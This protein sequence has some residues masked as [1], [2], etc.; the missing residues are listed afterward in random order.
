MKLKSID[1]AALFAR[2]LVALL[3]RG[4]TPAQA[5]VKLREALGPVYQP[6]IDQ[7]QPHATPAA[8]AAQLLQQST[9][10]RLR[11]LGKQLQQTGGNESEIF[12][13]WQQR[14]QHLDNIAMALQN[15]VTLRCAY[16]GLL[17]GI[18]ALIH[19]MFLIYVQPNFYQFYASL[20]ADAPI[21]MTSM[22]VARTMTLAGLLALIVLFMWSLHGK[23][24]VLR[25]RAG[26]LAMARFLPSWAQGFLTLGSLMHRPDQQ[27]P[28]SAMQSRLQQH[29]LLTG[30]ELSA[31]QLAFRNGYGDQEIDLLLS[32]P[33]THW[34]DRVSRDF[35][36]TANVLTLVLWLL[37]A[38]FLYHAYQPLFTLGAAIGS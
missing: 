17:S 13:R 11:D 2:H 25:L 27:A 20:Q 10:A 35:R 5:L 14:H 38:Q 22:P 6:E 26:K 36:R 32:R 19:I 4:E 29:G 8:T 12:R 7:L 15:Q 33:A 23:W 9:H 21:I 37:I 28:D 30:D 34:A 3:A 18:G 1:D 24:T 31:L 16:I